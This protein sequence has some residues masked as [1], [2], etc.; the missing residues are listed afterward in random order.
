[1]K[2]LSLTDAMPQI[3]GLI[4]RSEDDCPLFTPQVRLISCDGGHLTQQG[5]R[6][7]GGVLLQH[8]PLNQL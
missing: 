3:Q 6:Y 5:A 2:N 8:P 4:C 7:I 1:M